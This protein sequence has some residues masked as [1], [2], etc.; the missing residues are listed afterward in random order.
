MHVQPHQSMLRNIIE[1]YNI[2]RIQ[3]KTCNRRH[4]CIARLLASDLKYT[5]LKNNPRSFHSRLSINYLNTII[6]VSSS[7]EIG[8]ID[9]HPQNWQIC[10]C[11]HCTAL[12]SRWICVHERRAVYPSQACLSE[13]FSPSFC[14]LLLAAQSQCRHQKAVLRK[15]ICDFIGS[16]LLQSKKVDCI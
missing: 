11:V 15:F 16:F 10:G 13:L 3:I 8:F 12:F 4:V 5:F 9:T 2:I 6:Y 7:Q 14:L 1:V